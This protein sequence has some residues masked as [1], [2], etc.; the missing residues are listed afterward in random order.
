MVAKGGEAF[1]VLVL[2]KEPRQEGELENIISWFTEEVAWF[3]ILNT[4]IGVIM[5]VASYLSIMLFNYAAHSQV[6]TKKPK[7]LYKWKFL[8]ICK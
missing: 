3:A 2:N 5:L 1:R 4:I 7:M 8:I 6:I